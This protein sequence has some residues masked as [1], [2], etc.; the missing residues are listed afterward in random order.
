[1]L[2][3][4]WPVLLALVSSPLSAIPEIQHW[5]TAKGARV[6]F[7]E[8]HELPILDVKLIFSGGSSRDGE[9]NGL[10]LLTSSLLNEG[11]DGLN[12]DQ[13]SSAF[14]SVG[15]VYSADADNDYTAVNLRIVVERSMVIP[16]FENFKRVISRPDF[17]AS[18]F[19][20]QRKRMLLNI[21]KKQQSPS[22]LAR[23]AFYSSLYGEHPYAA[24][25]AGTER[26]IEMIERS[27][28][29]DFYRKYYVAANTTIAI[30]GDLSRDQA[31]ALAEELTSELRKGKR[32]EALPKVSN[33][34][35]SQTHALSHP[36]QQTHILVGQL[37]IK[38]RDPDYFAL[39]VGNHI[40]G[41][42]GMV[43]RLFEEI[44][45]KRG[46]SYTAYSYFA[47]MRE[48]GPFLAGLQTKNNQVDDAL[49]VLMNNLRHFIELGPS[50]QE[51]LAS[52]QNITGGFPLRLD[53]NAKILNY[54]AVIGFYNLSLDYLHT[55]N[56]KVEAVT[57]AQIKDAFKRR[58]DPDK[59]ITIMVGRQQEEQ[60]G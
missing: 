12:A 45:E 52:K 6:F 44:R 43:S 27:D 18:A 58:L 53:S 21:Q 3:R 14:E 4:Y 49:A 10:A 33:P 57:V 42:S 40:L 24:P 55:F 31:G 47:P 56:K 38:H 20:L 41:G 35:Q 13:I 60:G 50:E 11:A 32:P 9:L 26:S 54:T 39:Y 59:L 8:A 36:S 2:I 46:L 7:V 30:V 51:L 34:E 15:A 5:E 22:S 48:A 1:M 25:V 17:P 19:E 23:D 37:G 28:V 16:A 29:I